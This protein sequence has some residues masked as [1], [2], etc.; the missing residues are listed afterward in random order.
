VDDRALLSA[1]ARAR[2]ADSEGGAAAAGAYAAALVL[3]PDNELLASR[4]L[5]RAIGSGDWPLALRAAAVLE[6]AKLLGAEGRLLLAGEALRKRDWKAAGAHIDQLQKDEIFSFMVPIL[7]SWL[8]LDAKKGD[9]LALLAPAQSDQLGS[10][11]ANEVRP[12]LLL[13]MGKEREG[14]EELIKIA[15]AAGPRSA[16]LRIAGAATLAAKGRRDAALALLQGEAEPLIAARKIVEARRALPGAVSD[17]RSGIA[18]F[19]LRVAIDINGQ[20]AQRLALNYAQLAAFLAPGNSDA[21]LITS[22][23][24]DAQGQHSE[25]LR[26]A[27]N[28]RADDPFAGS[29]ASAKVRFLVNSGSKDAALSQAQAAANAPG[30]GVSDWARLG[31]VNVQLDRHEEAANAYRRALELLKAEKSGEA[32]WSLWLLLGGSL[33]QAGKWPEAKAALEAAY[34]LAPNQPVVLNYLGYA[35]LERRENIEEAMRLV[36]LANKL[37]PESAAITDSLGWAHYLQGDLPKAIELLEKAA[38]GQPVDPE[39]NEHLGDAYFSA[40]RHYEA[41]YAWSAALLGAEEKDASRLRA[42]IEGG[43]APKPASP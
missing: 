21:W 22:E 23:L 9:P 38:Q 6:K 1:Y 31:E 13:A 24:L 42:K 27:G 36:T 35:Q 2:A 20:G 4:A 33:E 32:E 15:D 14:S 11:Y 12:L 40:G 28:V 17:A 19:L 5:A 30:A 10:G 39:I 43:L 16:R 37:E 26:T 7:Q 34:K 41:R 18:E 29:A 8:A 25:A 3:S